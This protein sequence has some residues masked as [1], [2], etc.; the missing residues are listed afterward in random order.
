MSV[1][2]N[3]ESIEERVL[4]REMLRLSSGLEM[5]APE[6]GGLHPAQLRSA[7]L[8]NV[9]ARALLLQAARRR[10][11]RVTTEEVEAEQT[12]RSG[13][14]SSTSSPHGVMAQLADELLLERISQDL[15]RHVPRPGRVEVERFYREHPHHFFLPEAVKA[16]HII[17]S[18][19][20]ADRDGDATE[21]LLRAEAELQRGVPFARVADSYSD[22][23]G[24]GGSVG[25]VTR[26][27][28]VQEFEDVVFALAPGAR[29]GIFR[30]V[31]GLH[32]ATVLR[33]R[34]AGV[35]PFEEVRLEIAS[36]LLSERRRQA[37][38]QAVARLEAE[39]DIRVTEEHTA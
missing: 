38:A 23:K 10:K 20:A 37:L 13:H 36:R 24:V 12:R 31:F 7:A 4:H 9:L 2:V 22:C 16:A 5:D 25:W 18:V 15:V 34:K 19:P 26:G 14:K 8:R 17:R 21:V 30:T 1:I 33:R 11:L 3:G 29:S 35:Q 32:L 28:M 39:A 27:S 6:A